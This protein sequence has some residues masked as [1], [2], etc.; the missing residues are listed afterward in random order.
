MIEL[1]LGKTAPRLLEDLI[2]Y[3]PGRS[4]RDVLAGDAPKFIPLNPSLPG[5]ITPDTCRH[6]FMDK[7]DQSLIPP[8]DLRPEPG[9][10]YKVASFCNDCRCH[11][12]LKIE[13]R[14][15]I[16]DEVPCPNRDFPLHHFRHVPYKS[17]GRPV[18]TGNSPGDHWVEERVFECSSHVCSAVLTVTLSSPR[19]TPEYVALL[20]DKEMIAERVRR[21]EMD[22]LGRDWEDSEELVGPFEVL[23]R[24]R[25]YVSDAMRSLQKKRISVRNKKF[26]SALGE[27]CRELLE[28]LGFTF[29]EAQEVWLLPEPD[30]SD[31]IP[32]NDPV[33]ILLDDVEKELQLLLSKRPWAEY[34]R[35]KAV[36]FH[37]MPSYKILQ[38]TLG[39]LDYD[40]R[41]S[42]RRQ[43]DLTQDENPYYASLGALADFSDELLGFAYDRQRLCDPDNGPYYFE[44]LRSLAEHRQSEPL[45]TKAAM[46]ESQ[47]QI[48]SRDI[49]QAY[50]Y[51]GLR[52]DG[53]G[54]EDDYI[55]GT[56]KSR[57]ADAPRQQTEM[58]EKLR[59]IGQAR[60]SEKIQYVASNTVTTYEQAL[61]WLGADNQTADE[62]I[63]S[64]ATI[65][66]SEGKADEKIAREAVR[67]IADKRKSQGLKNWLKTG[68]TEE[69]DMDVGQAYSR[70][71][72]DDRTLDDDTIL[73]T[74]S[75]RVEDEPEQLNELRAAL[76]A[77]GKEKSSYKIESFLNTGKMSEQFSPDW[78]VGLENI[79]N[80]CYLN[81]LLQFYFTLK[82]LRDLILNFDHFK[83]EI[84]PE[85]IEKKKVGSR[86][87]S[88]KEVERAQKFA[89]ELQK[90]FRNLITARASAITPDYELAR[91]TLISSM[92]EEHYRRMS[93][94]SV[95][96]APNLGEINGAPIQ[97]PVGP[98]QLS[99]EMDI[100]VE[101]PG[102]KPP[103]TIHS[104]AGSDATL[105]GD[106]SDKVATH[107]EADFVMLDGD[108]T[109]SEPQVLGDKENHPPSINSILENP[110][111]QDSQDSTPGGKGVPIEIEQI[112]GA[113]PTPPAETTSY[114]P[115]RPPPPVP[116]RP[117]SLETQKPRGELEMGAQQDVT[118]VIA[119]VLFQ[120]ECAIKA[121]GFEAD[122]E[123]VDQIKQLFYGKTKSYINKPGEALRV[124]EEFFADIK[125]DVAA[126][127]RDI[128]SALDGA[129]DQQQ[130]DVDE[131]TA[132]QF[133]SI[134]HN[135]PVLQIQ[136]QRVQFDK[137]KNTPYKADSHLAL[138]KVIFLDRYMDS[139]DPVLMS[140]R[141]KSW[142]W[143]EELMRLEWRKRELMQTEAR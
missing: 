26:A 97:G 100:D 67:I 44:C 2:N 7:S 50:E 82:P 121:T 12:L 22:G 143:K 95:H 94:A 110:L 1:S 68:H 55:I 31:G 37:P 105:V 72:I 122:G 48:S 51:F 3:D 71:G 58:R 11:L 41:P 109:G 84:S 99:S 106:V 4:R 63:V 21:A 5:R 107:E 57:I 45:S 52:A 128:Y 16:P 47:G 38:R 73:T 81:S 75:L 89:Y 32:F 39:C 53:S 66:L 142:Q 111:P 64:L 27:D 138:E 130:I 86:K 88:R 14:G 115:E 113:P 137:A 60:R 120:L 8:L 141:E 18:S 80:T 98:P 76:K 92:N 10:V 17:T 15:N 29:D 28:F 127:P 40:K 96:G 59:I 118:E 6:K 103:E 112:N 23:S 134:S 46:L 56:Y 104:D 136:V 135:P 114:P 20:T 124:K 132:L 131:T 129:F 83:M 119:N 74:F 61:T 9:A 43:I 19:L 13:Y 30:M 139:D 70:L 25:Q 87:V 93:M 117:N 102:E 133:H 85:N 125:V 24:L 77:I 116:P 42:S 35:G 126:G 69:V 101:T 108:D 90:L 79:G 91:L 34:S 62:F 54:M 49:A 78:P 140:K 123:Q 36:Y 33:K 65:K